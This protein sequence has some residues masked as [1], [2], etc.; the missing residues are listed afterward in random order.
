MYEIYP[1]YQECSL[2]FLKD[3]IKIKSLLLSHDHSTCALLSDI[4]ESVLQTIYICTVYTYRLIQKTMCRIHI[5]ILST[6][7]V[8][9]DILTVINTRYTPYVHILHYVHIYAHNNMQRCNRLY[10]SYTM[11]WM[12]IKTTRCLYLCVWYSYINVR[13]KRS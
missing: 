3:Q 8:I 1:S 9:L 6:H 2:M 11:S 13:T 4:L 5:H 10:I 7:S 12:C